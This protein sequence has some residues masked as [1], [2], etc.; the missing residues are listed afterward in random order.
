MRRRE[1]TKSVLSLLLAPVAWKTEQMAAFPSYAELRWKKGPWQAERV[2]LPGGRSVSV[3][4]RSWTAIFHVSRL[5]GI[6]ELVGCV[7]ADPYIEARAEML[8][9]SCWDAS[10]N[11]RG[12]RCVVTLLERRQRGWNTFLRPDSESFRIMRIRGAYRTADFGGFL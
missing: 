6:R 1:F 8:L 10:K 5:P 9:C 7:N 3:V 12:W 11:I 2:M 4:S